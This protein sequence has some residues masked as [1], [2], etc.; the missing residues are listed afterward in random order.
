MKNIYIVETTYGL[1]AYL[2]QRKQAEMIRDA[3]EFYLTTKAKLGTFEDDH[4]NHILQDFAN[5]LDAYLNA[6]YEVFEE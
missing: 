3:I 5:E 6:G 4:D 1:Q 2:E